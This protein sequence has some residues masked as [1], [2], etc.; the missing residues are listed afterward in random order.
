MA[1]V[2]CRNLGFFREAIALCLFAQLLVVV[3][4]MVVAKIC[5]V[6]HSVL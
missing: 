3:F 6:V 2:G 5:A 4:I 1:V